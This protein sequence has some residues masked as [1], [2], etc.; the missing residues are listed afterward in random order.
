MLPF[1]SGC[2]FKVT[3]RCFIVE[4]V[5]LDLGQRE[6]EVVEASR[7]CVK[8]VGGDAD[9]GVRFAVD[10]GLANTHVFLL[11]ALQREVDLCEGQAHG[12]TFTFWQSIS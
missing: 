11:D 2:Y 9:G 4:V 12:C 7:R 8:G 6:H 5:F 1:G 10:H 3:S